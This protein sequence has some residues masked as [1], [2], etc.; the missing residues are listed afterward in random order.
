VVP[1]RSNYQ[2]Q[3]VIEDT[4]EP[5]ALLR[6]RRSQLDTIVRLVTERRQYEVPNLT[7][8]PIIG[9][10]PAYLEWGA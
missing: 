1:T 9:G 8:V 10:N 4:D 5:R 2:W 6:A 7:A 3:G